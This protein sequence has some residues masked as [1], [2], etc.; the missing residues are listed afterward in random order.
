MDQGLREMDGIKPGPFGLSILIVS[1]WEKI[2]SSFSV[3]VD[4][5]P[6]LMH[7]VLCFLGIPS[8]VFYHACHRCQIL[9]KH[10]L[11]HL[12]QPDLALQ[13][14]DLQAGTAF[15]ILVFIIIV[16][17]IVIIIIIIVIVQA[18][19]QILHILGIQQ[20]L[21]HQVFHVSKGTVQGYI[22]VINE[23]FHHNLLVG[24]RAPV[25]AD[26][27]DSAPFGRE[28]G[29]RLRRRLWPP[30][31]GRLCRMVVNERVLRFDTRKAGEGS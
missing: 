22:V 7:L 31:G 2:L 21:F 8:Q 9:P 19:C 20:D 1:P 6:E 4:V 26:S 23:V 28:R 24:N 27:K 11:F 29:A 10:F 3:P 5:V 14:D 15:M 16:I 12:E 18:F 30:G 17:I 13:F 25:G